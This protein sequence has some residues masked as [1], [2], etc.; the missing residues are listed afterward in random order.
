M[1]FE[2][3]N[4]IAK[5]LPFVSDGLK[6]A[7]QYI[8][9]T[10]FSKLANGE[11]EIDGRKVFARVNT[12]ETEP[13]ADRRPEKHNKYIDVQYVAEGSETIWYTPLTAACKETENKAE[14]DDVIFYADLKEQN[15]V[16]LHAGDFAVFFPWELHRPNCVFGADAKPQH[17]QKVVVKVEA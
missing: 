4:D 10:D 3:K 9:A 16:N 12:Y 2:N 11:Y 6:Q 7:L 17:V 8:A 1:I 13:K 5:V 15:C 14:T